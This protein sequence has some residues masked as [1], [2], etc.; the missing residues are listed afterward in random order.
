MAE[1]LVQPI[2]W[3]KTPGRPHRHGW[4]YLRFLIITN[5]VFFLSL[6]FWF[7][8]G[9]HQLQIE[10]SLQAFWQALHVS[11]FALITGFACLLSYIFVVKY[12]HL[13]HDDWIECP[14]Q[15]V[16]Y[17]QQLEQTWMQQ[18]DLADS[19]QSGLNHY[20]VPLDQVIADTEE[21]AVNI[22]ERTRVLDRE[23]QELVDY[24]TNADFNALDMQ[25][26]IANN[27]KSIDSI[28]NFIQ[29][30]P[31]QLERDRNTVKQVA[32]EIA[33]LTSTVDTIRK[34]SDQTQLLALNAAIEAAHAREVGAGF[35]VVAD[36]VKQ[37]A[38]ESARAAKLIKERINEAQILVTTGF[39]NEFDAK[40]KREL[41]DA[42]KVTDFISR[43]HDNYED[44]QQF[45]KTLLT[46]TT[47]RNL[48][49]AKEIV[50]LLG[51]IQYQ[52]IIRQRIERLEI[53][54]QNLQQIL[55]NCAEKYRHSNFDL[56]SERVQCEAYIK[57]YLE[58]EQ[59]H[60][61]IKGQNANQEEQSGLPA[62]ELF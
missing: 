1:S 15:K 27:T 17:W 6:W 4:A 40:A 11:L 51:N 49:L 57:K 56:E 3:S 43:L 41:E 37:L 24:L 35:A 52:D 12:S 10:T 47:E 50:D 19:L 61:S 20:Q 44:M 8:I 23:A 21:S 58:D 53:F 13:K 9:S 36:E 45:Y 31:E 30:L 29:L 34:I 59:R 62:I 25:E 32:A 46:V 39:S 28:A 7:S 5:V 60:Q 55:Q 38:K 42:T 16:I 33:N 48:V 22:I 18:A 26:E 2:D 54:N 14:R